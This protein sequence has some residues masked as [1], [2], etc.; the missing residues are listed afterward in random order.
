VRA[1]LAAWPTGAVYL[2]SAVA[3]C[4]VAARS[5]AH[6]VDLDVYRMGG[7]AALHGDRLYQL[8]FGG[9]PFTYPPFAAVLF[10]VAAA[11]P[12]RVAVTALTG[13][14]VVALPTALYLVL[15][16]PGP[17]REPDRG[18]AW[19]LALA[20]AAAAIWLDPARATLGYGQVDILL[21][22]A[23][24]YDLSLPDASRRKGAAIG[25]AA[26]FK[27]TPA[28]FAV[29]LLITGRRRAAAT[30]AAVFAGTVAVGFAM[31]PA[32]SAW[33]W[34]GRFANPGH[35]SPVQNPQNQSLFGALAR[36]MHTAHVLP[37]WLP[38]AAAL[39]AGG[40]ALAA[41]AARRGDEALGFSLCAVTGLLVS[42]ISWIHHWVIAIPA[43]LVAGLAV[44]RAYR[45][46]HA[47]A[48]VLGAA[49]ITAI[50]VIGWT[51]LAGQTPRSGWLALPAGALA[52]SVCYVLIGLVVL[53]L[54]AGD[55][56]RPTEA[57]HA[58]GA[59]QVR[60]SFGRIGASTGD[61]GS[62][63]HGLGWEGDKA[64]DSAGPGQRDRW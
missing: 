9:L 40:L 57:G 32:S 35:V 52:R 22:M 30:A 1:G 60:R 61:G 59:G 41:A 62:A 27:L 8:Q 2:A 6:F 55:R 23:V 31:L 48:A 18:R 51:E 54:A 37:V 53:A 34:A 25:L 58:A 46:G 10:T 11:V 19:R 45:A 56:L 4:A 42:P 50:A 7:A 15:R 17:A 29:Y 16:L 33:F 20:T 3:C 12:W 38:L 28:I 5:S 64:E 26:G 21:T 24:L 39:T 14:S 44:R 49:A 63:R 13:A 47:V 43:L 36:T